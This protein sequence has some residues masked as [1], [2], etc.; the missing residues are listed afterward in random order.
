MRTLNL[1]L[2]FFFL[3]ALNS[4]SLPECKGG[5]PNKW[6]NCEGTVNLE[7]GDKYEGE[8]RSGVTFHGQGTYTWADGQKYVGEWKNGAINGLGTLTWADGS[9]YVGEWKDFRRH[10]Q[11][12]YTSTKGIR[13]EGPWVEDEFKGEKKAGGECEGNDTAKWNNCIGTAFFHRGVDGK[14]V[15]EWK[16]GKRHGQGSYDIRA[17]TYKYVG[18]WKDGKKHG[19]GT[20]KWDNRQEYEGEW[21]DDRE[22]GKGYKTYPCFDPTR[23][24]RPV[25]AVTSKNGVIK[26]RKCIKNCDY[27]SNGCH[28]F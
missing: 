18:E 15:G 21:K 7:G 28:D 26:S 23:N 4:Y 20:R 25:E 6:N 2:L 12:T 19:M 13:S 24:D 16:D 27:D 10:G 9:K 11:G 1:F 3:F 5:D 17:N 22:H 14:Y 8:L